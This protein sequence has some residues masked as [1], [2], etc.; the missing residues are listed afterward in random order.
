M[1]HKA[2]PDIEKTF[3]TVFVF[4]RGT[5]NPFNLNLWIVD[6]LTIAAKQVSQPDS[7]VGCL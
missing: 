7:S 5:T 3:D 2:E 6:I 4:I 1:F